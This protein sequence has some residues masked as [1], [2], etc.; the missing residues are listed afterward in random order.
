MVRNYPDRRSR[1]PVE[2]VPLGSDDAPGEVGN[3][4]RSAQRGRSVRAGAAE[5]DQY[6]PLPFPREH[7]GLTKPS[8]SSIPC[9]A[10]SIHEKERVS[11]PRTVLH[12]ST[13]V[14]GHRFN[15]DVSVTHN[16][17]VPGPKRRCGSPP[18]ERPEGVGQSRTTA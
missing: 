17:H 12:R 3:L 2:F 1:Q 8:A 4:G 6:V 18:L 10:T 14:C 9:R 15:L 7:P 16:R 13:Q 5:Y 11:R